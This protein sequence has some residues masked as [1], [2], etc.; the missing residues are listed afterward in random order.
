M[1]YSEF[2]RHLKHH[3]VEEVGRWTDGN[4]TQAVLGI[5]KDCIIPFYPKSGLHRIYVQ[6]EDWE[7]DE[8]EILAVCRRFKIEKLHEDG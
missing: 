7:L 4:D 8:E 6:G 2:L 1:L 5:E 3:E